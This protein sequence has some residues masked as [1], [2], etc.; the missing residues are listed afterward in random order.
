MKVLVT[1]AAGQ[2]GRE[3]CNRLRE[4]GIQFKG[5]GRADF[6]LTEESATRAVIL[7]YAPDA[8]IHCAAYTAVDKAE[9]EKEPCFRVNVLGTAN[10]AKACR[11]LNARMMYISTDYVFDGQGDAPFET[12]HAKAPINHYGLTKA[13]GEDEVQSWLEK[14]FI[15][16]IAWVFGLAGNNFV[17]TML[18]LGQ[19]RESVRVVADQVGS[20]TYA[21]DLAP[22]LCSMIQTERYGV[23]HATN[24]GFCSWFE[25]AAEIMVRASLPCRV[26]P[27]STSD[28]PTAAQRPQNSRLSKR[29]L[30]EAGFARLPSWQDALKRYLQS[31]AME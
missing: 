14:Y 20:P 5:V 13:M 16:R 23:Y 22:L 31:S 29:S 9:T 7:A 27:I 17:E 25:F 3:V 8:V 18:R 24:E 12:D 26:E 19:Q 10:V 2:L 11:E 15:I 21:K 1:G 30:D 28:Y 4:L 6:D